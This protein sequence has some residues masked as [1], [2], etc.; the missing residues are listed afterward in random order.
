MSAEVLVN[1]ALASRLWPNGGAI[2]ARVRNPPD[3]GD[4]RPWRTR[5]AWEPWSTVVGVV[6]DTRMPEV[7]GDVAD[8]QVYSL[9]RR[10]W[11]MCPFSCAQLDRVTTRR[12]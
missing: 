6:D 5:A 4:Q 7:R 9:F 12:R 10:S 3:N 11:A 8:M 2:G 1:R